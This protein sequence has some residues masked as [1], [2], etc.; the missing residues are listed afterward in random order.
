M[1]LFFVILIG[2]L[3]AKSTFSLNDGT[4]EQPNCQG[5]TAPGCMCGGNYGYEPPEW[6]LEGIEKCCHVDGYYFCLNISENCD[7]LKKSILLE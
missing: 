1:K 3:C 2:F 7:S 5:Q 4:V 6:C